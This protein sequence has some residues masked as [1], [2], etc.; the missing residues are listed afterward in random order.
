[1]KNDEGLAGQGNSINQNRS[2]RLFYWIASTVGVFIILLLLL[3]IFGVRINPYYF[4]RCPAHSGS[5]ASWL[6]E[7]DCKFIPL[8]RSK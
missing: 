6:D 5:L 8:F 1:M 3:E 4:R 7:A 2:K